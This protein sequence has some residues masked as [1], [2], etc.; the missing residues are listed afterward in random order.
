VPRG[1]LVVGVAQPRGATAPQDSSLE[2]VAALLDR[3]G[4]LRLERDGRVQPDL[5]DRVD[6]APDARRSRLTL[7]RG[8]AFH[9]GS[10]LD[11][12]A[13]VAAIR[14]DI[15][16]GPG[17][18]SPPALGDIDRLEVRDALT[19][20]VFTRAPSALLGEALAAIDLRGGAAG[21]AGAGPFE[22]ERRHPGRIELRAFARSHQGTP[23]IGR[24][25]L[26]AFDTP[27]TA[28]AALLRGDIAFLYD[29]APEAVP[30]V[31]RFT[32]AQ[33]HR[34]LRPFVYVAG[35]NLRHPVLG[36][37]RVRRA[38]SLAVDRQALVRRVL[39]GLGRVAS[40]PVWPLHWAVDT[41]MEPLAC[42]PDR[43]RRELDAA[44]TAGH[45]RGPAT[46]PRARPRAR[47]TFTCLVPGGIPLLE[48]LAVAVQ[49]D[50]SRAG[51]DMHLEAVAPDVLARRLAAGD[52]DSYLLDA[53]ASGLGWTHWLWHSAA[54]RSFIDAGPSAVDAPLERMRRAADATAL[55][56]AVQDA[57]RAFRDDPPALF[58]CWADTVRAT[59]RRVALPAATDRDILS[60]LARWQPAPPAP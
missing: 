22:V 48:A 10:P 14:H 30:F 20:D 54:R 7:R 12:A 33:V 29:V 9:D 23:A 24:V 16:L 28:W 25:E 53:N 41:T 27:R 32:G 43:A 4:L 47:V 50:L 2:R 18:R 52:F 39:H 59:S 56:A 31:E 45:A 57:R 3:A 21:T 11:A 58:L 13:A 8:L 19:I 51:V 35:F 36:D 44:G 38:L 40:D 42:D 6:V 60:S 5:A 1:A 34:F 37:P 15:A 26:R 49:H 17:L 46:A 55:R